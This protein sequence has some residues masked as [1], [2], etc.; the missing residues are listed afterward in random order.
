MYWR[1]PLFPR[2]SHSLIP[3]PKSLKNVLVVGYETQNYSE[4][5]KNKIWLSFTSYNIS[6]LNVIL[7]IWLLCCKCFYCNDI[8]LFICRYTCIF[9][10]CNNLYSKI[11]ISNHFCLF[12]F[13]YILQ[14]CWFN[15]LTF[16]L[17]KLQWKFGWWLLVF[18]HQIIA[19][20]IFFWPFGEAMRLRWHRYLITMLTFSEW[21]L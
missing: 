8:Y 16:V 6:S 11:D 14:F 4:L 2:Y 3:N 10:W 13:Y 21:Q 12:F 7:L 1:C 20:S 15:M 19:E 17:Q 18:V 9:L 5:R